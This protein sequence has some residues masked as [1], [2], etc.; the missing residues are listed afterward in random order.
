MLASRYGIDPALYY[1]LLAVQDGRC[2]ICGNR[3]RTR[4]LHLDHNHKTGLTRGLLCS[5]CNH[6]LL[7]SAHESA[8]ILQRAID[9]LNDP[10]AG[11]LAPPPAS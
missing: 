6:G 9:Y 2:A 10:P 8:V 3:P 7:G 4:A 11:R 1:A 5:R